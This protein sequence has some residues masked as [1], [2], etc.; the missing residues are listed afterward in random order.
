MCEEIIF[1][2]RMQVMMADATVR[3]STQ[4]QNPSPAIF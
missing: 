1:Y 4:L 2:D 3:V